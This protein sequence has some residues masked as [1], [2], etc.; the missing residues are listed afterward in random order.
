[1]TMLL[2]RREA[3][4]RVTTLLGGAALVGGDRLLLAADADQAARKAVAKSGVGEFTAAD[5]A[6]LDEMAETILP[7]TKTPGA[8][9]ARTGAFIALMVTDAYSARDRDIFRDGM[10]QMEQACQSAHG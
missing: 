7:E 4:L 9:A 2:T 8:K 5:I 10:R 3:V 1:M 6:L